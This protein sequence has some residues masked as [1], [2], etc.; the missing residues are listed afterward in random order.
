MIWAE[1]CNRE[2]QDRHPALTHNPPAPFPSPQ[3]TPSNKSTSREKYMALDYYTG[4]NQPLWN[5][6]S[7]P[8]HPPITRV[9]MSFSSSEEAPN[10]PMPSFTIRF[11]CVGLSHTVSPALLLLPL[12]EPEPC[13]ELKFCEAAE[14]TARAALGRTA[15]AQGAPIA[16][17]SDELK[18]R[19][20][21]DRAEFRYR[22]HLS[23]LRTR[24]APTAA[25][26]A[27]KR[28]TPD[29]GPGPGPVPAASLSSR[30]GSGAG[31]APL[32]PGYDLLRHRPPPKPAPFPAPPPLEAAVRQGY[33]H[34][35]N[36][37]GIAPFLL[38]PVSSSAPPLSP[39][40]YY[41]PPTPSTANTPA[42]P[43]AGAGPRPPPRAPAPT[44]RTALMGRQPVPAAAASPGRNATTVTISAPSPQETWDLEALEF[45]MR[46]ALRREWAASRNVLNMSEAGARAVVLAPLQRTA[47]DLQRTW[48]GHKG[49]HL[50]RQQAEVAPVVC[51]AS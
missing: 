23:A 43:A 34:P 48:R 36:Y 38:S 8:H 21:L 2:Q 25:K 42:S 11:G 49:R 1:H 47:T 14:T 9:S 41:V 50:A 33:P 26:P 5:P 10:I 44:P 28:A 4:T 15:A 24:E 46:D 40:R 29:P 18:D 45:G 37:P 19:F 13:S 22:W 39:S 20:H 3:T 51:F 32:S 12:P 35:G 27:P 17:Q 31:A 30:P 6:P 7:P 16:C